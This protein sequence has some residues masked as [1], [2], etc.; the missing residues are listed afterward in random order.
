MGRSMA[1]E[2]VAYYPP[3]PI[4][5]KKAERSTVNVLAERLHLEATGL[6]LIGNTRSINCQ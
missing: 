1:T 5:A 6:G 4:V 3:D 2:S